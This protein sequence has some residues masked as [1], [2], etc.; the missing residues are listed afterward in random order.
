MK[1]A[2]DWREGHDAPDFEVAIHADR[3]PAGDHVGRYNAP[4]TNEVAIVL[5]NQRLSEKGDIVIS[6]KEG[7]LRRISE[8]NRAY[9]CLQYPLMFSHGEDGYN[10]SISLVNPATGE[11]IPN[12]KDSA[13]AFY[14]YR[15][16]LRDGE[17]NFLH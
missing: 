7:G 5:V 12:K 15:M 13:M 11:L 17:G 4:I 14:A 2:L 10:F 1:A 3:K 8:T 6:T 16:M 9:D